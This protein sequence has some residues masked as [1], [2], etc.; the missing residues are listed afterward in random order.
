MTLSH[1]QNV[2]HF[3]DSQTYEVMIKGVIA[4]IA[5]IH[6]HNTLNDIYQMY[7]ADDTLTCILHENIQGIIK[8]VQHEAD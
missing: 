7:M 5:S 4:H 3:L 1:W 6:D 8:S 2:K